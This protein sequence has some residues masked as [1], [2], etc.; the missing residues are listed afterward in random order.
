MIDEHSMDCLQALRDLLGKPIYVNSAFRSEYWN[1]KVG[2]AK[3]SQH[4]KATAFDP[5]MRNHDPHQFEAAA[6]ECG[7][8]SFGYYV[9]QGFMHIDTR[10]RPTKW[11][12]PF[13]RAETQHP[14]EVLASFADA[15]PAR[16]GSSRDRRGRVIAA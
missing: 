15:T 12:T 13:P 1:A 2:G 3:A 16:T 5:S 14:H 6:R 11:G 9:A 4:L 10:D 7:F 8:T